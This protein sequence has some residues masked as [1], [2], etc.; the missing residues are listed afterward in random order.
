MRSIIDNS[1]IFWQSLEVLPIDQQSKGANCLV[2]YEL[3]ALLFLLIYFLSVIV[4]A[5]NDGGPMQ[6]GKS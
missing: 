6:K 2:N 5:L 3:E 1:I 4:E